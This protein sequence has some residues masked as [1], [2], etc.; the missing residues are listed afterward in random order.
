MKRSE[1]PLA[2]LAAA[3]LTLASSLPGQKPDADLTQRIEA[4]QARSSVSNLIALDS[5][6]A[7]LW[8]GQP[9]D[10][11]Q[12]GDRLGAALHKLA[13]TD[14]AAG[15]EVLK[16]GRAAL[17]KPCTDAPSSNHPFARQDCFEAKLDWMLRFNEADY[18]P[19]DL[20]TARLM[21]G[22][23]AE[24]GSATVTNYQPLPFRTKIRPPKTPTNTSPRFI[25]AGM[26]PEDI[27][28]P[29]ARE[30]YV[31]ALATNQFANMQNNLQQDL[32][33]RIVPHM[34]RE[35]DSYCRTLFE[36]T[37]AAKKSR[38]ELGKAAGL[39]AAETSKLGMEPN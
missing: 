3:I 17:A 35:F 1:L 19:P 4:A 36:E 18:L 21:A 13:D 32:Q 9:T 11:F 24:A 14:A 38:D 25:T 15:A 26:R 20:A 5:E 28:D 12:A 34:K 16:L 23:V 39:S 37:T 10:Y 6:V 22:A 7:A 30:A 8:P 31:Q 33:I 27:H 29:V 2:V